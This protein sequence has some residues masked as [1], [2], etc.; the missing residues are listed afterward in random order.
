MLIQVEA[1]NVYGKLMI[2]PINDAAHILA[3]IAGTKTIAPEVLAKA[4]KLGHEVR[5]VAVAKLGEA[6]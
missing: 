3:D 1:R 2:Y 6:A 4:K 5:E